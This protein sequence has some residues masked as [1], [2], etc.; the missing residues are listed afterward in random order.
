MVAGW[1]ALWSVVLGLVGATLGGISVWQPNKG[2]DSP[3]QPPPQSGAAE[4][5]R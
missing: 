3:L 2:P 5:A 1:L 4:R